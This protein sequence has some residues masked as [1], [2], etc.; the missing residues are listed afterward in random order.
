MTRIRDQVL[1][2]YVLSLWQLDTVDQVKRRVL[3]VSSIHQ[4]TIRVDDLQLPETDRLLVECS[5]IK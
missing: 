3:A 5:I 4:Q 2:E 1:A